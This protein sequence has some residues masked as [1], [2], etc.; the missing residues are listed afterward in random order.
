MTLA[1]QAHADLASAATPIII[2]PRRL[3]LPT[4]RLLL[5][6]GEHIRHRACR[7]RPPPVAVA[8][9][10]HE[11]VH[12]LHNASTTAGLAYLVANLLFLRALAAGSDTHGYFLG[13]ETMN[14]GKLD[15][16]RFAAGKMRAMLGSTAAKEMRACTDISC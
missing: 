8:M 15:E 10:V 2:D 14:P 1:K 5:S 11:Y 13:P 3:V 12:F 9:H 16:L 7:G 4:E 6:D